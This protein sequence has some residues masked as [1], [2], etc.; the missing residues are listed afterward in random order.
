MARENVNDLLA[1]VAVATERSF[2][3]A[4]KKIGISPSALS[5]AMR[6]LEDRLQIRLLARTTRDVA[7]T[8]AGDRLLRS[9][10]PLLDQVQSEV[11]ALSDLRD[12]PTGTIRITCVDYVLET[13][14]RPRLGKFLAEYPDIKVEVGIDYGMT[15]IVEQ[16]YDAG[17]R[18]G[19]AVSKDMIAVRIGPDWRF[20][21]VATPGYFQARTEPKTPQDL[22]GHNCI[23]MRLTSAGSLYAWE[24]AKDGREFNV[25]VDGQLAFNSTLA[26]LDAAL[27]GLGVAY[28]PQD[29][30][31]PHIDAGRLKE[32]LVEWCPTFQGYH[33]YYP[34]RRQLSPAFSLLV[35]AL[36]HRTWDR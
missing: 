20:S 30:A 1:F 24:F 33:L 21:V 12:K 16:R 27:D 5:H 2:T 29:L 34:N 14:L 22:T 36:R 7:P 23:N 18:M 4:A 8:E 10:G 3:K 17:I 26:V 32:V 15:N 35:Q 25:R 11:E 28:I 6:G 31:K 19:E 13:V 9:I